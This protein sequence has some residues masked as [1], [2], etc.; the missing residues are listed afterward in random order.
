MPVN[1]KEKQ[2]RKSQKIKKR[3]KITPSKN[4]LHMALGFKDN[5]IIKFIKRIISIWILRI[6]DGINFINSK[7][8]GIFSCLKSSIKFIK[9]AKRGDILLFILNN[10]NCKVAYVATFYGIKERTAHT[11][12]NEQLGWDNSKNWNDRY[13][14]HYT[15]LYDL[16]YVEPPLYIPIKGQATIR[17]YNESDYNINLIQVLKQLKRF[18]KVIY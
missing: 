15:N 14:L 4:T 1:F 10:S 17:K 12:T 5:R 2:L 16:S 11:M 7:K 8:Y 3:D 6:G 13:E 18:A 9:N